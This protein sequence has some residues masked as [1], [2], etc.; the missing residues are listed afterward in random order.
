VYVV[1]KMAHGFK[2]PGRAAGAGFYDYSVDPPVLWSGL[3]AFERR[4]A[5]LTADDIRER[6]HVAVVLAALGAPD[7]PSPAGWPGVFGP[8][9]PATAG[10][11]AAHVRSSGPQAFAECAAALAGRFGE[12]FAPSAAAVARLSSKSA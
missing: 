9:V 7:A 11:A 10:D 3:K 5:R 2:R 6:L 1:E 4:S 8:G 12:R